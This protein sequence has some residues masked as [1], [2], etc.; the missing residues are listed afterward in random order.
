ML[1]CAVL[2]ETLKANEIVP[3]GIRRVLVRQRCSCW[4]LIT[5]IKLRQGLN[6]C[7][8][9][10]ACKQEGVLSHGHSL[11]PDML[12]SSARRVFAQ[13]S[14]EF[15]V[16]LKCCSCSALLPLPSLLPDLCH[17]AVQAVTANPNSSTGWDTVALLRPT[18]V[19]VM[20]CGVDCSHQDLN[21]VYN[22]SFVLPLDPK[23]PLGDTKACWDVFDHG[24]NVAGEDWNV[25]CWHD[26]CALF[27]ASSCV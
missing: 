25:C 13:F 16:G 24:T 27:P 10:I 11:T 4:R 14:R 17:P 2:A 21:V 3:S 20:D 19:A 6:V 26:V 15:H 23:D 1:C 8:L 5:I 12:A 9:H 18:T 22:K 7:V